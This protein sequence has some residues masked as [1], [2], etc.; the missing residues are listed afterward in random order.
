MIF[1]NEPEAHV[2][3]VFSGCVS[4]TLE[5]DFIGMTLT[6][7]LVADAMCLP[8]SDMLR[9]FQGSYERAWLSKRLGRF[10]IENL[11]HYLLEFIQPG[12]RIALLATGFTLQR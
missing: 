7:A 12:G 6:D 8:D 4:V 3:A 9:K 5:M 2:D 1:R 10:D 11:K